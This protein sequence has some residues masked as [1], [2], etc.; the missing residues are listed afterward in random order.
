MHWIAQQ[1]FDD[2]SAQTTCAE[3]L[4]AVRVWV[5]CRDMLEK[6]L[7]EVLPTAPYADTI[8]W[9]AGVSRDRHAD[10]VGPLRRDR[11]LRSI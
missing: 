2:M 7:D 6:T 4:N 8:Y 10:G 1:T 3:Y 11:R 9:A 5:A